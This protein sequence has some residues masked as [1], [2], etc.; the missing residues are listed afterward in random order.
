VAML[1]G[2][3][4]IFL[5]VRFLKRFNWREKASDMH[6]FALCS[7]ALTFFFVF[8]PLQELDN[9][10]TDIRTGMSLVALVFAIGLVWLGL[11]IRQRGKGRPANVP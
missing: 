10:R 3:L 8:A 5:M 9:T 2:L 11:Q 4:L 6:V 7:G 1:Y